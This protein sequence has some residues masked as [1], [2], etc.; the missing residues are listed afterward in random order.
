[1]PVSDNRITLPHALRPARLA[2]AGKAALAA[3]IAW[4]VG[5]LLPPGL[6]E[7]AYYAPLGALIAMT[8]TVVS[9][10]R[11]SAQLVIGLACGI[12]VAWSLVAIELPALVKIALAV[13]AG[14]LIAGSRN[15]GAGRDYVPI[16]AL[17]TLLLGGDSGFREY[18]FGYVA[19]M[20]VGLVI[21]IAV[22]LLIAPPLPLSDVSRALSTLR[23][24]EA[25][26]LADAASLLGDP[27]RADRLA[28]VDELADLLQEAG[29]A[30]DTAQESRLANPRARRWPFDPE[31]RRADVEALRRIARR[32]HELDAALA[33]G[34]DSALPPDLVASMQRAAEATG[35]LL[36]AWDDGG[37]LGER[38]DASSDAHRALRRSEGEWNAPTP[39]SREQLA[40]V[41]FALR[42]IHDEIDR[43]LE[44]GTA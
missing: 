26:V 41:S 7:Y 16:A 2:L 15:L 21:G 19:Q 36:L 43:R 32:L 24:R 28:G 37:A 33:R 9:S 8:P 44:R 40:V 25:D 39:E 10:L 23:R 13:A 42:T 5:G 18:S 30:F 34:I 1:M 12:A 38:R 20:A 14:T 4:A 29:R 31:A 3:A 27:E 35:D 22:N 17:F 11:S 6:S